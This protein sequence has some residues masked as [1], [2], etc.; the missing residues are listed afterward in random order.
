MPPGSRSAWYHTLDAMTALVELMDRE[1]RSEC[2]CPLA[3]YDVLVEI[4]HS[5]GH[6]IRMSELADR[7]LLSRSWITRRVGQLE[8][9][10]LIARGAATEDRRGITAT[11]TP[12]GL[13]AFQAMERSHAASIQ[14][15]FGT[16]LSAE[17]ARLISRTFAAIASHAREALSDAPS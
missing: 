12:H 17:E 4:Y 8:G 16:H 11:L 2:G 3:F 14:R 13:D 6:S 10:G 15:H 5:P 1:L 9:A 7:V